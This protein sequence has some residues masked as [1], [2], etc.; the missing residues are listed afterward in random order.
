MA[1]KVKVEEA[2]SIDDLFEMED[3]DLFDVLS[4]RKNKRS[5]ED[6]K[7]AIEQSW[8]GTAKVAS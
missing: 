2:P 5:C 3:K 1:P 8:V 7:E 4:G 6:A